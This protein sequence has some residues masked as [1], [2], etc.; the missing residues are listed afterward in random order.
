MALRYLATPI[1]TL[2]LAAD[3]VGLTRIGLPG[4]A[5]LASEHQGGDTAERLLDLA[6]TQLEAYFRGNLRVFRVPLHPQ[7]TAFQLS[8]WRALETIP[9]GCTTSYSAIAFA[10]GN[11][12][13]VRAVGAANGQNPL[14]IVVPCH[15]VIGKGGNLTGFGGG[16]PMKRFLLDIESSQMG[17]PLM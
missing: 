13:A 3:E 2:T 1:G 7:G 4:R 11:P 14:P 8:V 5:D 12:K 9:F 10:L 16:L 15:R 17:L 6:S